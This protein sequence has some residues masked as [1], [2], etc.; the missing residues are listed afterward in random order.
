MEISDDEYLAFLEWRERRPTL[1]EERNHQNYWF[2]RARDLH[3]AAGAIWYAMNADNDAK[4]AQDLGLG[5]GFSMSIACGSVYHMLC[6]QSLEVVMKAA[7]VSRDQSPPQTHSLNDLA[8]LLGVNRSKEEK[9]LLAFYEESVW[10]AGRYPIPKKAND[11]MIRDFWKLSSN[12]LTKPKKMDG[13]SFVEASGATDWG[14]Y[15][16]LWLKYA[17]LFDHKFGS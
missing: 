9:R 11:K 2:N 5:H 12:V 17:E 4:V 8:D 1:T 3:A 13:L 7:L 16:S 10:W 15:D 14:K 6:G